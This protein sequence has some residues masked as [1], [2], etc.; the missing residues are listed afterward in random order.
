MLK[1]YLLIALRNFLKHKIFAFINIF[2][3]AVGMAACIIIALYVSDELS[4]DKFHENR[5]RIYRIS[6]NITTQGTL[7]KVGETPGPFAEAVKIDIPEAESVTRIQGAI[8]KIVFQDDVIKDSKFLFADPEFLT[9]FSFDLVAGDINTALSNPM[10]VVINERIAQAF[11]KD[12]NVLG[13]TIELE[14]NPMQITGVIKNVPDNSHLQFEGLISMSTA[15]LDPGRSWLFDNWASTGFV[16]FMMINEGADTKVVSEKVNAVAEKY[17]NEQ[18]KNNGIKVELVLESLNDIYLHSNRSGS[19][20]SGSITNVYIFSIVAVLTLL[21]AAIN[22]VNLTTARSIERSKEIGLRKVI[23][24]QRNQV[25]QQF[26][27]E[28]ALMSIISFAIALLLVELFLPLIND[29]SGKSLVFN[30]YGKIAGFAGALII[31]LF[32]GLYPAVAL[33]SFSPA[34]ALKSGDFKF[35]SGLNLR[36]VLVV[37]Q[38]TISIVLIIATSVIYT[39][40]NHMQKQDLGFRMDQTLLIDYDVNQDVV[41][42]RE[43]LKSELLQIPG[44]EGVT[45]SQLFMGENKIRYFLEVESEDGSMQ[46]FS[47][48]HFPVD[49]NFIDEYGL[50]LLAGRNFSKEIEAD[51]NSKSLIL[52]EEALKLF[53]FRNPQDAIGKKFDM[54][55][56]GGEIIGV[57]R[58]FNF[59]SLH[60]PIKPLTFVIMD[61]FLYQASVMINTADM[62]ST[63]ESIKSKWDKV[64]PGVQFNYS[65]LDDSFNSQYKNE[66]TFGKIFTTFSFIA[67]IIASLGLL[68]LT[69]FSTIKRRK[70]VGVRKVMGASVKSIV[71]LLTKDFAK[72]VLAA[73]FISSL[74]SYYLINYWLSG[75]AYKIGII[76]IITV[77]IASALLTL[78]IAFITISYL[79]I[80]AATQNPVESIRYE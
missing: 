56:S 4:Y 19:D 21:I 30:I 59:E 75:F 10:S 12:E 47:T 22:F 76:E 50:E 58:N 65:F 32:S 14:G 49:Y 44:V 7:S 9:M 23:G 62:Q 39:Q 28:S 68:G 52:N 17:S 27:I 79:A 38:F 18:L 26:L 71:L 48:N 31:G 67:V 64:F 25:A 11:F 57:V 73:M 63:V 53:G 77:M 15:K 29:I 34:N 51:M 1:N 70:E 60:E 45:Y 42:K 72:L 55:P 41:K 80:K 35:S 37:T 66:V 61:F 40:L 13:K 78:F 69:M 24:A 46:K 74:L 33:S 43:T 8:P 20:V 3:F 54:W 36:K 5:D 2:G 6:S 16:A